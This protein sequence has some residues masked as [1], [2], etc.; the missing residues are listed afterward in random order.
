[1]HYEVLKNGNHLNPISFYYS[2]LN[3]EQYQNLL[4]ISSRSTQ[5]FD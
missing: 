5:S 1:V 2:D 4:D 3:P